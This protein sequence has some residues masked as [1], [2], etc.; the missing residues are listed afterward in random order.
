LGSRDSEVGVA[1]I[2][3]IPLGGMPEV[4]L[5]QLLPQR[6]KPHLEASCIEAL[7]SAAPPKSKT[8]S[9]AT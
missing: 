6:L 3:T 1:R 8:N 7:K 9:K 5:K 2:G 4:F